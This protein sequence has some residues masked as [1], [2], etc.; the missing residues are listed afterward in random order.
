MM[1]GG[2]PPK[3]PILLGP[4]RGIA[5]R[6]ST[7]TLW[8]DDQE[9]AKVIRFIREHACEGVGVPDVLADACGSRST[10]ER[11]V[12]K[13]LGRTIK[14]EISR[15]Q[16]GRARLL[17]SETEWTVAKI[18]SQC[19]FSEPK[20]FCEIFRRHAGMTATE[21]RRRFRDD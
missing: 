6:Q 13:I 14:E 1:S 12:K 11:R 3:E 10:L 19:G 18:S 5:N 20:Y 16:L 2:K 9:V 21:F 8:V 17:L 7:N 4:P 15:V